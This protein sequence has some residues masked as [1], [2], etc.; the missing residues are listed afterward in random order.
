LKA[1]RRDIARELGIPA[2]TVFHDRS[3]TEMAERRPGSLDA[4]SGIHGVGAAKLDK[5]GARFLAEIEASVG[6][7]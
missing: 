4:L 1:L 3:L 5:F 7:V 2:Y 6:S